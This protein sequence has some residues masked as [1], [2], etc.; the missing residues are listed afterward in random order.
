MNKFTWSSRIL[1]RERLN[2]LRF[3]TSVYRSQLTHGLQTLT[4]QFFAI[5]FQVGL[6]SCLRITTTRMECTTLQL[7]KEAGCYVKKGGHQQ[8]L[9]MHYL[10]HRF[11]NMQ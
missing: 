2:K 4:T 5:V 1:S 8:K 6:Q 3:T 11:L 9:K 10:Y 7:H